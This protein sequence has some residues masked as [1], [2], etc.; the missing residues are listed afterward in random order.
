MWAYETRKYFQHRY[1][2]SSIPLRRSLRRILKDVPDSFGY[3]LGGRKLL[4]LVDSMRKADR[5]HHIDVDRFS[6]DSLPKFMGIP[7]L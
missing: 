7:G 6:L 4:E 3:V 1:E 5:T 2:E